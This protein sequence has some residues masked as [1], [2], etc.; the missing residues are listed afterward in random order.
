MEPGYILDI[1]KTLSPRAEL[2][3]C[4]SQAFR[5]PVGSDAL[6]NFKNELMDDF[7]ALNQ[8][9]ALPDPHQISTLSDLLDD[10]DDSENFLVEYSR[11]FLTPPTPAPLNFGYYLDGGLYGQSTT[12]ME[13]LYQK[14]AMERNEN[15]KDL[16]D[17]L[18]LLLFFQTW[19]LAYAM[20]LV[21]EEKTQQEVFSVLADIQ[22]S[23]QNY[24]L[25]GL[26]HL[27]AKID[28]A[29]EQHALNALYAE[30]A[31]LAKSVIE[32]DL[33]F[34]AEFLPKAKPSDKPK[35]EPINLTADMQMSL[36]PKGTEVNCIHQK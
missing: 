35:V 1:L 8:E 15:F 25:L 26:N 10:Y 18:S 4:L 22:G 23:M 5:P 14:Y 31:R 9:V 30:L 27:I 21:G 33:A 32:R 12:E 36:N 2:Y 7:R 16:P 19:G 20:E 6:A 13:S 3:L 34:F 28:E 24:A 11:F 29:V 17:H